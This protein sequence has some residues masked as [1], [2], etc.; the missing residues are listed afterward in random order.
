MTLTLALTVAL[1]VLLTGSL[2]YTVLSLVAAGRYFSVAPPRPFLS[3]DQHP[4]A[5]RRTGSTD[6]NSICEPSLS[7]TIPHLRFC[8]R[9]VRPSDPA[10]AVVE[11]LQREYPQVSSRLIVT[12]EPPYPNAKVFSLNRML[13]AAANDL[14][15]MS[16]SDIRVTQICCALSQPNFRIPSL[17]VTTCPYRAVAGASFWSRLEAI[18]T[19]HRF[20]RGNSGRAH[21]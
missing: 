1:V 15:V 8:S 11:K 10:V 3:A 16:D 12:G 6:S 18:G 7:R 14:V 5:A 19:E 17:G 9:C 21:A 2:V 4:Q 20:H 13:A